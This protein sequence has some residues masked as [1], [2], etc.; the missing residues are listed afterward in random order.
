MTIW[1]DLTKEWSIDYTNMTSKTIL[2][3]PVP[4]SSILTQTRLYVTGTA[5]FELL[6]PK[7]AG[8]LLCPMKNDK[9]PQRV[10]W[11]RNLQGNH[12]VFKMDKIFFSPGQ[13]A[14]EYGDWWGR[15]SCP[16]EAWLGGEVSFHPVNFKKWSIQQMFE[17]QHKISSS[18]LMF[19]VLT[20][21]FILLNKNSFMVKEIRL[22]E[23]FFIS[24]NLIWLQNSN[25][26]LISLFDPRGHIV[27]GM[28]NG[29]IYLPGLFLIWACSLL[30]QNNFRH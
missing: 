30:V 27:D 2:H 28:F 10:P 20:W 21:P 15:V 3:F 14:Y 1:N 24:L 18:N 16:K 17:L 7:E 19:Y 22:C 4:P 6:S 11:R 23:F 25:W 13:H 26:L 5:T 29:N 8:V 12:F 9:I